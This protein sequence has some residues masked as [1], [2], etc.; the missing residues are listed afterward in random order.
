[1]KSGYVLVID[2]D[3]SV[4]QFLKDL[5][6][7][8]GFKVKVTSS[9][10]EAIN[11][12]QEDHFD[13]FIIDLRI[14]DVDGIRIFEEIKKYNG[15][16][17][18]ILITGYPTFE[19]V[20]RALRIGIF[21]YVTKPFDIQEILF[22]V[23]KAVAYHQ[24]NQADKKLMLEIQQQNLKLEEN[25][26]ERT[27][28]LVLLYNVAQDIT[29]S[30]DLET[31]LRII[32]DR[33]C[34]VLSV[35]ICSILLWDEKTQELLIKVAQGLDASILSGARIKTGEK[36]SGWVFEKR[37][38]VLVE[39]I[40]K[41]ARFS[42]RNN[43]R[44]YT[45]SFISV[46]LIVKDQAIGVLNVNNKKNKH[47]FSTEDFRLIQTISQAASVAIYNAQLYTSLQETYIRT[48]MALSSAIDAKDH[49]TKN[50]SERLAHYSMAIAEELGL[51]KV[52]IE[53][54]RLASYLHDVGK[55]AVHDNIL[56]KPSGLTAHEWEEV[57]LHPLKG[58]AILKPLT[59]LKEVSLLVEQHHERYDGK[60]YPHGLKGEE[61]KIGARIL[62]VVD[63]YDAMITKRP[64]RQI[65]F[66]KQEALEE[67]KRNSGSQFDPKIVEVFLRIG[68]KLG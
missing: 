6:Q 27:K 47:M 66:S 40:E 2:D 34:R 39:D 51:S 57:R 7:E 32:V 36:V 29:K 60:G 12:A 61:I 42:T 8:Q 44:Y 9:G 24:L 16:C 38:P 4:R 50:H 53:H 62:S 21:D 1:M 65:P 55:I 26:R 68:G 35:E 22:V 3:E 20:Q 37:E 45:H 30:L 64:Y 46:P 23:R 63:T 56:G 54:I 48:V 59:F 41:D 18:G 67:I 19:T 43:E 5:L 13:A 25:V 52:E 11:Q 49:Y 28:E 17:P 31:T 58:A 15:N 10:R 14:S 33:V